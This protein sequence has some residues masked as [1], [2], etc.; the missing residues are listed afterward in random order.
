MNKYSYNQEVFFRE[1]AVSFYLLGAFMADGN[2]RKPPKWAISISS[3]DDDW[4]KMIR[5]LIS[6]DHPIRQP[7]KPAVKRFEFNCKQMAEWLF[8]W[9][10]VPNKSLTLKL[11]DIPEQYFSHFI[12]GYFDGNGHIKCSKPGIGWKKPKETRADIFIKVLMILLIM[13]ILEAPNV[14]GELLLVG[15]VDLVLLACWIILWSNSK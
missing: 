1:D 10:C 9:G 2:V 13:L 7:P 12:R 6:P 14:N 11:P 3:K 4:L 15:V 8:K 5:D